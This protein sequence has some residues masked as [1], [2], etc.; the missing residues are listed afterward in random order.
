MLMTNHFSQVPTEQPTKR[1]KNDYLELLE[2]F[3]TFVQRDSR[4]FSEI[5]RQKNYAE[6]TTETVI[7]AM[8]SFDK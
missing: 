6:T 7:L 1:K 4:V 3:R 2:H 5:K 8:N